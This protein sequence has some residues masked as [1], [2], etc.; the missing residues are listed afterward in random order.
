MAYPER[1]GPDGNDPRGVIAAA[2]E[3]AEASPAICRSIFLDWLLGIDEP[4]GAAR[5]LLER[6]GVSH[7]DHPMTMLLAEAAEGGGP[8]QRTQLKRRGGASGRRRIG[9]QAK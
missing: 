5:A 3:M 9:R 7:P 4:E 2:Y 6:F 8:E 1:H